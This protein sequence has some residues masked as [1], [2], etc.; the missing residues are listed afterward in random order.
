MRCSRCLIAGLLTVAT[1][2][3]CAAREIHV[4]NRAG[5]DRNTGYH[6]T[7]QAD[8]SGPVRTIGKALRL[9]EPS[10]EVVLA[11]TGQPYRESISLAGSRHSGNNLRQFVIRGN[12]QTLDGSVPVPADAWEH[13]R[14]PVFRFKPTQMGDQRLFL[15]G[16]PAVQVFAAKLQQSPPKMDPLEWCEIEGVI[17]FCA[18]P[19][20]RPED[21][22]LSYASLPTGITLYHVQHVAIVDLIVQGFHVDGISAANS[23][24]DVYIAGATCRGNGRAGVS[25]GGA[26]TV[27]LSACLI[28][29][30]G[31]AQLLT[32]PQ[33]ETQLVRSELVGNTAPGWVD[34]GGRV[35]RDGQAIEGGLDKLPASEP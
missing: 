33:S 25:V 29:D 10:D 32:L 14:G 7:N 4:D 16:R 28:G 19:D 35:Y 18:E 3:L 1:A 27:V 17:Y 24:R 2:G 20:R 8:G 22:D 6:S 11:I 15:A 13:Y 34:R 30:N 5:D 26:S 12:G 23:A 9:A 21:Y 31:K